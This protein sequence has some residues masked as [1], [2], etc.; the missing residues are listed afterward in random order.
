MYQRLQLVFT[1]KTY[2]E[3]FQHDACVCVWSNAY[4]LVYV[5]AYTHTNGSFC[6]VPKC[7]A[8]ALFKKKTAFVQC[9]CTVAHLVSW[10]EVGA[11]LALG[12]SITILCRPMKAYTF[13]KNKT[14]CTV[15]HVNQRTHY[16]KTK[17]SV[18]PFGRDPV[19]IVHTMLPNFVLAC[20][21]LLLR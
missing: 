21:C 10:H 8:T 5:H 19:Q 7:T 18:V 17:Q 13:Q 14:V 15:P 6:Q 4:V 2:S 3:Y 9:A 16:K 11:S 20:Q 1:C 12:E